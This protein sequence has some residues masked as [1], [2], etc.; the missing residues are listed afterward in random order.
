MAA[1]ACIGLLGSAATPPVAHAARPDEPVTLILDQAPLDDVVAAISERTGNDYIFE[2]PLPGR[3]TIAIPAEVS[4]DEATQILNATLLIKGLVA[5]PIAPTRYTIVRWEKMAGGAPY[6][7]DALRDDAEGSVT[8]RIKLKHAD[9]E[10]VVRALSPL[11]QNNAQMIPYPNAGSIIFA[12]AENRVRRL[13]ELAQQLD[14]AK[15][16]NLIV[17]RIRYRDADEVQAQL[18]RLLNKSG[19]TRSAVPEVTI[20]V[21]K[22]TNALLLTGTV[23]DLAKVREWIDVMDIPAIGQGEMHVVPL[24]HQDPIA[25]AQLLRDQSQGAAPKRSQDSRLRNQTDT[26]PLVGQDYSIVPH[27][28]TR[29]LVIRAS[30]ETF[31]VLRR[32]IA[33]LDK[34]PRMVRINVQI[35]EITTSGELGLGTGAAIPIIEQKDV[36]DPGLLALV[37]PGLLNLNIPGIDLGDNPI[38]G[39]ATPLFTVAGETVVIPVLD[40]SGLPIVGADGVPEVLVI[41]GLGVT[42]LA[43]SVETEIKVTQRPSLTLAVGEESTIFIG[44]N[45]PIPVGSNDG[46]SFGPGVGPSVR[47]EIERHDVGV[48]LH[49]TPKMSSEVDLILELSLNLE[50]VRGAGDPQLGPI[51]ANRAI[52]TTFNAGFDQ[53]MI[54]A[55]LN[56]EVVLQAS[57]GIPFLSAIPILGRLFTA[58]FDQTR[59]TYTVISVEATLIPT[60][61]QRQAEEISLARAIKRL[62]IDIE[63]DVE[64][65]YAIRVASYY[66]ADIAEAVEEDLDVAPWPTL[67]KERTTSDGSRFDLYVVGLSRLAEV[68]EVAIRVGRA[69]MDPEIVTLNTGAAPVR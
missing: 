43:Q 39:A 56:S 18:N 16:E 34:E 47:V 49:V 10:T 66:T 68:A 53:R 3:V 7:E 4:T 60:M 59:R 41:P 51:L 50:L 2:S 21:D 9:P 20:E 69:G 26:G 64:S 6:T 42:L 12:G 52:E 22:R 55:G 44:D 8:T 30:R 61:E 45:I 32:L 5:L 19:T 17:R 13:I 1:A 46:L 27:P 28:P 31:D 65:R 23:I 36:N 62:A 48:E 29:S 33:K 38:Q 63:G 58:T 11:L 25:L 35:V 37:N 15:Q 54:I 14:A 24:I 40:P 67:I 57:A